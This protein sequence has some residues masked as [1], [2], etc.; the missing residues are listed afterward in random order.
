MPGWWRQ[1]R[2]PAWNGN[3]RR[4][5]QPQGVHPPASC[6]HGGRRL[7][8]SVLQLSRQSHCQELFRQGRQNHSVVREILP[9][10]LCPQWTQSHNADY[11][12]CG[13]EWSGRVP[14]PRGERHRLQRGEGARQLQTWDAAVRG[15][16]TGGH[17]GHDALAGEESA[18]IVRGH[19]GLQALRGK[20]GDSMI[21]HEE[22]FCN[23]DLCFSHIL[24]ALCR[25]WKRI[26]II[27]LEASG[28]SRTSWTCHDVACG[29]PVSRRRTPMAGPTFRRITTSRSRPTARVSRHNI[30]VSPKEIA[31]NLM[32]SVRFLWAQRCGSATRSDS[33]GRHR[34]RGPRHSV[35]P[36]PNAPGW[37][38]PGGAP[39]APDPPALRPPARRRRSVHMY[40]RITQLSMAS[41][42]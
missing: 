8:G 15:H 9:E 37:C 20:L 2:S 6:Q 32:F 3:H 17:Q 24:G 39:A 38:Y 42:R 5:V 21:F 12:G 11:P 10:G 25:C 40:F 35:S 31:Y 18:A 7:C 22:G 33:P 14:V 16:E 26:V 29:M 28:R 4:P 1:P 34:S 19:A 27:R 41:E 30:G 36:R 13:G 23:L